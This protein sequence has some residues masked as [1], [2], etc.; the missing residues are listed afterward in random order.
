MPINLPR[1]CALTPDM[2]PD[3]RSQPLRKQMHF[4]TTWA[5]VSVVTTRCS[6]GCKTFSSDNMCRCR[7]GSYFESSGIDNRACLAAHKAFMA[8]G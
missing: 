7:S 8:L 2:H 5:R 1:A 4:H 3:T 6:L